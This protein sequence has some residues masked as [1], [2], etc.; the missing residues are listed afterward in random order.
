MPT[1][2]LE[3]NTQNKPGSMRP[4][5]IIMLKEPQPGQVK[6]RLAKD[7]GKI[8]AAWWFRHQAA[9]LI[10]DLRDPRWHL[11]LA[12]T[13]DAAGLQSRVW[14]V[15][16]ARIGQGRGDLGD[17]MGRLL[18]AGPPGARLIIG[19][20]IPDIDKDHIIRALRT[21]SRH[22]AV[23]GPAPD[24]GY[25]LVGLKR[26]RSPPRNLFKNVRWST[27]HALSDTIDTLTDHRIGFTDMLQDVDTLADLRALS[28]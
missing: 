12:V 18:R 17:R 28:R 21:L 26:L 23:L 25:W 10:R 9:R 24:G 14:P 1:F 5:L 8:P 13:P 27:E 20:D 16:L 3:K 11:V 2:F 22:D 15:D 6:T 19:S 4:T 7:L